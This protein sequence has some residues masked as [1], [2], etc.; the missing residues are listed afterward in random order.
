MISP[1]P[2]SLRVSCVPLDHAFESRII[3][4][5]CRPAPAHLSAAYVLPKLYVK[6]Q[7]C[8]SCAIH[9]KQV[10]NRSAAA[11]KDRAPPPRFKPKVGP[12][13]TPLPLPYKMRDRCPHVPA[14]HPPAA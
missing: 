12:A 1:R 3:A 5:P 9:S 2:P 14:A 4:E 7:Y 11:R 8:I 13:F 10:R 6:M